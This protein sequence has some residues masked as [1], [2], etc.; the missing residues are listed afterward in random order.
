[1]IFDLPFVNPVKVTKDQFITIKGIYMLR[2]I[3]LVGFVFTLSAKG[4]AQCSNKVDVVK[5][6]Y[7]GSFGEI[8]VFITTDKDFTCTLF[9]EKATGQEEV[10]T[11]SGKATSKVKFNKLSPEYL[12]RVEANFLNEEKKF[13][14]KFSR[15]QLTLTAK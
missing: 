9:I 15:S 3:L 12:Y 8:E 5:A 2:Y 4:Q 6:S 10:K 7:S 11:I 13:C 14:N 1:M